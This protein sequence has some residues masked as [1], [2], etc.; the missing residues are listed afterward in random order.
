[1]SL[2][3]AHR[4]KDRKILSDIITRRTLDFLG[5]KNAVVEVVFLDGRR[6]KALKKSFLPAER[7]AP[8]DVLAFVEPPDFPH[9]QSK[10]KQ[11]GEVYLNSGLTR[12][13]A[14]LSRLLVHGIL[15]L[16]GY[17]HDGK[18]DTLKMKNIEKRIEKTFPI[19]PK[20]VF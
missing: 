11:L 16:A 19:F 5:V 8:V 9:P 2:L 4:N 20:N 6:M 7:K 13:P 12:D 17:T 14:E 1:M 3:Q 15:H 10:K 18:N